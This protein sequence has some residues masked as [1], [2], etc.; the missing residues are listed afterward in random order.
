MP[1]DTQETKNYVYHPNLY[2]C[3]HCQGVFE[4][5]QAYRSHRCKGRNGNRCTPR[6]T[7]TRSEWWLLTWKIHTKE[8]AG[9][10]SSYFINTICLKNHKNCKLFPDKNNQSWNACLNKHSHYKFWII[11]GHFQL[12]MGQL[13]QML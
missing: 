6:G 13:P 2:Y 8:M 9:Y 5:Q 3:Q 12:H 10:P 4:G 7:I 11:F 1:L